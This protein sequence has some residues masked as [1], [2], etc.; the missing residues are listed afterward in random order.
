MSVVRSLSYVKRLEESMDW[1][2]QA[3]KMQG[4]RCGFTFDICDRK[5][6]VVC[7]F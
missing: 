6:D 1:E 2:S 3:W 5:G 4:Y 7:S